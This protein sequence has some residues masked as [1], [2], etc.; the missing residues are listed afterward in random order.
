MDS[1]KASKKQSQDEA[2]VGT[3]A[4]RNTTTE[5]PIAD[6]PSPA[7][8]NEKVE[9]MQAMRS[10]LLQFF[11]L[12]QHSA[13]KI[14][15]AFAGQPFLPDLRPDAPANMRR[16]NAYLE[17]HGQIVKLLGQALELW[18]LSFGFS[19]VKEIRPARR[20]RRKSSRKL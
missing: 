2:G 20:R 16:F 5:K 3:E 15:E 10:N 6:G 18:M 11:E 4:Q 14:D 12:I 1:R 9:S 19:I 8:A 7:S 17:Q 13:T